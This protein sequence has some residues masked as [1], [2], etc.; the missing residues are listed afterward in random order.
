M[1]TCSLYHRLALLSMTDWLQL[2][3]N[4]V[5]LLFVHVAQTT[6]VSLG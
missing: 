6:R 5:T 4:C 3:Y 2:Y 1:I